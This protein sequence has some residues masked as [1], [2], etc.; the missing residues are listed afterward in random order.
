MSEMRKSVHCAA[1]CQEFDVDASM[2]YIAPSKKQ[3]VHLTDCLELFT[4]KE[5]L[6]EHDPWFG[7]LLTNS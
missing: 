1:L 7:L 4:T 5:R 3:S 6:G 2:D